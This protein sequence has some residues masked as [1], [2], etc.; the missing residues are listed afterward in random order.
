MANLPIQGNVI[1]VSLSATPMGLGEF[2]TANLAIFTHEAYGDDFGSDPYKIYLTASEVAADFGTDSITAKMANAVFAQSPNILTANGY[3]AVIP[4]QAASVKIAFSNIPTAGKATFYY[5]TDSAKVSGDVDYDATAADVQTALR[6]IPALAKATVTGDF[7]HG[8]VVINPGDISPSLTAASNTL[9]L[10]SDATTISFTV[11]NLETLADALTRT[12]PLVEYV[13]VT[14]T[15]LLD[16]TE[17]LAAAAILQADYKIGYF[18][19][20]NAA[21][22][23]TGSKIDLL[24]SGSFTHS[25]G[26][27]YG[28]SEEGA[29]TYAAAYASRGQCVNFSGSNTT[30]TMNLK[31][32]FG[33]PVDT[34]VTQNIKQK[35][36][37]AGADIYCSLDGLSCVLSFGAN[38]YFDQVHNFIWFGK[39]ILTN[40]F[41]YLRQS[42]NKVPLNDIGR[43]ALCDQ[44]R[45][46]CAQAIV[47]GYASPGTW[48]IPDTF[49][50]PTDFHRNIETVGYFVWAAS[51]TTM[52]AA[53]RRNRRLPLISCA[54]KEASAV[55]GANILV[56]INE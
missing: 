30:L 3:L 8:F 38:Q 28:L 25:R 50:D 54:L 45:K 16:Q 15:R 21:D 53:Q 6:T 41:N 40:C 43:D 55:H 19:T 22:V 26:L 42:S 14:A 37:A 35:C 51:T 52:S 17:L 31:Q 10:D 18:P 4:E 49:G 12:T 5:G 23:E 32:L 47:N 56:Y 29:L 2:N 33:V 36:E 13:G 1:S 7:E 9:T 11:S 39:A 24:R 27:Y 34:T 48:T 20:T 46:V 44:V